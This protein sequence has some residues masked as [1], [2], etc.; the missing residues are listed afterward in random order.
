MC[1]GWAE[2][3]ASR[4]AVG[5]PEAFPG[6]VGYAQSVAASAGAFMLCKERAA[7]RQ[8]YGGAPGA[9]LTGRRLYVV[10]LEGEA[11][12][13]CEGERLL[14]WRLDARAPRRASAA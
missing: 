10:E 6:A 12:G 3:T 4:G 14:A 9:L 1:L 7:G 2:Q 13:E 11:A 8:G 5:F